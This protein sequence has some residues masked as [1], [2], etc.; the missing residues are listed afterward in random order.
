MA[1]NFQPVHAQHQRIEQDDVGDERGRLLQRFDS[2]FGE[3][4]FV[5]VVLEEQPQGVPASGIVIDYQHLH[6]RRREPGSQQ[7]RDPEQLFHGASL[8]RPF[9]PLD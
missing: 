4:Q 3:S 6:R 1:A 7:N 2:G 9:G 5:A 8:A